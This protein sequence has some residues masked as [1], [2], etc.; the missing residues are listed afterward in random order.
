MTIAWLT[1]L[2]SL[3]A[4]NT[5]PDAALRIA[6][7]KRE[8][9]ATTDYVEV[10]FVDLLA[11]PLVVRGTLALEAGGAL[12]KRVDSPYRETTRVADGQVTIERTGKPKRAFSLRRAPELAGFL[13]SFGA[14]LAGDAERLGRTYDVA[15]DG[16]EHSWHVA[17]TPKDAKF[18]RHLRSVEV[19]GRDDAARCF[20]V[21]EEGGDASVLLVDALAAR[22]LPEPLARAALEARC[23]EAP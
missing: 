20:I 6:A 19:V 12:V 3:P 9:P 14:L 4:A 18:R 11:K 23:R 22:P 7:L 17:L 5:A 10:R 21:D 8:A 13:E 1:L 15:V 2:G 16:N